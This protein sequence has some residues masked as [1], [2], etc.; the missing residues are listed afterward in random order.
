MQALTAQESWLTFRYVATLTI[1]GID[2]EIKD[3]LRMRA[4][5]HGRSME[6]EAR[7][8]LSDVVRSTVER[9]LVDILLGMREALDGEPLEI[10]I[11]SGTL[12]DAVDRP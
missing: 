9:S 1:R 10:P 3:G 7:A 5:I 2:D 8:I 11:R 12:G 4:A 6:A